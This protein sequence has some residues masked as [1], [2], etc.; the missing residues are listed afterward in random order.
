VGQRSH[1][2]SRGLYFF[3]EKETKIVNWEH[4][5]FVYHRIV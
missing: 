2:K 1:V 5:F 4:D 3:M